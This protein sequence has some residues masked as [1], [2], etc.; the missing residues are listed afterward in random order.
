MLSQANIDKM[1]SAVIRTAEHLQ[2]RLKSPSE[3]V[4]WKK[5]D[6]SLVTDLD[7]ES[8][9]I[10]LKV[11][12]SDIP[13]AC[14]EDES[15]HSHCLK[16]DNLWLVDPLD[17]TSALSRYIQSQDDRAGFGPLVGYLHAGHLEASCFYHF[18]RRTLYTALRGKGVWFLEHGLNEKNLPEINSRRRLMVPT[19]KT[20]S[21]SAMYHPYRPIEVSLIE[22][23]KNKGLISGSGHYGGFASDCTRMCHGLE[24]IQIQLHARAWDYSALLLAVEAGQS[25]LMD[26]LGERIRLQDW[27]VQNNN[28]VLVYHPAMEKEL[29]NLLDE[30]K[31][32]N[33]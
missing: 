16:Y 6:Q 32:A 10:I 9:H 20:T 30:F 24:R 25:V 4:A 26:P 5:S 14:E 31:Q 17:G 21:S 11:L 18:P 8:Q 1:E 7:I 22:E 15:T 19:S 33:P 13:V 2:E 28:P 29:F 23:L 12:D 27:T 3:L